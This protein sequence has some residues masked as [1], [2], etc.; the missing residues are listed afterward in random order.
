MS[1]RKA[2]FSDT[3]S[4]TTS[5]SIPATAAI[6]GDLKFSVGLRVQSQELTLTCDPFSKVDANVGVDEIYATLISSKTANHNQTFAVTMTMSGAHASLQHQ[7]SG[8]ASANV[9][10]RDLNLSMFN[11]YQIRSAEPGLSAV[12]KSSS[13]EVSL[14]ARQ[15]TIPPLASLSFRPRFPHLQYF[16]VGGCSC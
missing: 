10:L 15:G 11:N 14:N 3:S 7:Y 4:Q 9:K 12:I 8:I 2:V 13:F 6:L 1:R 16:M 5:D